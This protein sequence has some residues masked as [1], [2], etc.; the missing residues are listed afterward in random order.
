M[1]FCSSSTVARNVMETICVKKTNEKPNQKVSGSKKIRGTVVLMKKNVLDCKDI[2]ASLLDRIHE[3][4]GKGVS[5]H[6]I[7]AT[8]PEPAGHDQSTSLLNQTQHHKSFSELNSSP[9]T[10]SSSCL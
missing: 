6:L 1:G 4:L 3:F 10:F 8:H 2:T 9:I 5:M 7:S